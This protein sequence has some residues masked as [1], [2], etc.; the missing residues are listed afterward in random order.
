MN[1][2]VNDREPVAF[3]IRGESKLKIAILLPSHPPVNDRIEALK[4]GVH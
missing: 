2:L 1:S 4:T 3:A